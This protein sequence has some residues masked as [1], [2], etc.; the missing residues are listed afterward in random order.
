MQTQEQVSES[1]SEKWENAPLGFLGDVVLSSI[2]NFLHYAEVV[3]CRGT[4]G[5]GQ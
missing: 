1:Q 2:D 3:L 5:P 4:N